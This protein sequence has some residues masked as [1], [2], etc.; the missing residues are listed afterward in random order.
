[1]I[2]R[3]QGVHDWQYILL[4][5]SFSGEKKNKGESEFQSKQ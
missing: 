4:P 2:L 5:Q 3:N 1:M